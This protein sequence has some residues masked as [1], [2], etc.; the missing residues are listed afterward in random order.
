MATGAYMPAM[1]DENIIVKNQGAIYLA[2][3]PLVKAALGEVV[4]SEDLGGG[5]MHSTVSGVTDHLA[6]SD[7]HALAIARS[8]V[9][10]LSCKP[11]PYPTAFSEPESGNLP[12]E[13][14]IYD[15]EELGGIVGTNLK[16]PFEMREVIARVVDGSRFQEWKKDYGN[17]IVTGFAHIHGRPVGIVSLNQILPSLALKLTVNSIETD[18]QQ[19]CNS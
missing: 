17:T 11:F 12:V 9:K 7:A 1:A 16:K 15:V 6:D 8:S 4:N 18:W 3:P 13:E 5:A 2:G 19:W 10:A 14:P